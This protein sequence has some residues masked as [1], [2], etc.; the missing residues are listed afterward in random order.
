M[1]VY[2]GPLLLQLMRIINIFFL[3]SL[4][5]MGQQEASMMYIYLNS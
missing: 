3:E 2:A 4:T 5:G 1:V